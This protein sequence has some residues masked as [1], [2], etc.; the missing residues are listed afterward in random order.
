MMPVP[1]INQV[2]DGGIMDMLAYVV[3]RG[4]L[5]GDEITLAVLGNQGNEGWPVDAL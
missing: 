4:N 5:A 3:K 2:G 1:T